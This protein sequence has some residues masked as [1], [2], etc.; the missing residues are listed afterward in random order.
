MFCPSSPDHLPP[1]CICYVQLNCAYLWL[2]ICDDN[3]Q[4]ALAVSTAIST[5]LRGSV[6]DGVY[7]MVVANVNVVGSL[8]L[9]LV[10]SLA[11]S[12]RDTKN[13]TGKRFWPAAIHRHNFHDSVRPVKQSLN[14]YCYAATKNKTLAFGLPTVHGLCMISLCCRGAI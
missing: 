14:N 5:Q 6:C 11:T 7:L 10:G 9:A 3:C 12:L 4:V 13:G 2:V 1:P 8:L